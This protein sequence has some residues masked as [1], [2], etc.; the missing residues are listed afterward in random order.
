MPI[1]GRFGLRFSAL[2]ILGLCSVPASAVL[3]QTLPQQADESRATSSLLGAQ[4]EAQLAAGFR[5][6]ATEK[7]NLDAILVFYRQRQ[8]RKAF[9]YTCTHQ[10]GGKRTFRDHV[11]FGSPRHSR[12]QGRTGFQQ[13][14]LALLPKCRVDF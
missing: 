3:A 10:S 8:Y 2:L 6:G 11:I 14:W 13:E 1:R 5:V 12:L 9:V 4:I 7:K